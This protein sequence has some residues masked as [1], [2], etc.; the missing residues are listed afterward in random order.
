MSE[1]S[2]FIVT[3]IRVIHTIDPLKNA[4]KLMRR[5]NWKK[6]YKQDLNDCIIQL[7]KEGFKVVSRSVIMSLCLMER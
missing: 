6:V 1:S 5:L 4:D 3:G 7:S 2:E